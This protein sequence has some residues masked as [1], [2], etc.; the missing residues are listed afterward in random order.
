M[1]IKSIR[2]LLRGSE[3]RLGVRDFFHLPV[4]RD[5]GRPCPLCL[6]ASEKIAPGQVP[7]GS[8]LI[9]SGRDADDLHRCREQ[10][11]FLNR[12]RNGNFSCLA[13]SENR[14]P[15]EEIRRCCE[16]SHVALFSSSYDGPYLLSRFTGLIR[17]RILKIVVIH[18]VLVNL[19]GWGLLITG[20]AGVGK[21]TCGL[22]LAR[23][24][25][26]W[27]A[28]DILEVVK[29]GRRLHGRGYG[30]ARDAIALRGVG[31]VETRTRP[32]IS[33]MQPESSLD[34][35]C[36][37]RMKQEG[38]GEEKTR[39]IMDVP[40]PFIPFP[41]PVVHRDTPTLIEQWVQAFAAGKEHV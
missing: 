17:E 3:E 21:T 38:P 20:D 24:G 19:C 10:K 32:E 9:L 36:E 11:A 34:L 41:S 18:G 31:V 13:F 23:R 28:D 29:R 40:L 25:H 12:I 16:E 5:I 2:G 37:L 30:T 8:I 14:E 6:P 1:A 4:R 7:R 22:D 35:W 15:P 33:R 27:I 39:R 26:I